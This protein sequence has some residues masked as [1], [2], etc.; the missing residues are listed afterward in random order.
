M[1][2]VYAYHIGR[3]P[4]GTKDYSSNCFNELKHLVGKKVGSFSEALDLLAEGDSATL[5]VKGRGYK[6]V[7]LDG[8][9]RFIQRNFSPEY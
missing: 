2:I 7:S 5:E 1:E 3:K 8:G 9:Q 4:D 6:T